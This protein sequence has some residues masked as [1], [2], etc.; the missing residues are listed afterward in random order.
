MYYYNA[1]INDMPH[2]TPYGDK[3]GYT[4]DLTEIFGPSSGDGWGI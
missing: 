2:Y 4:G 1:L 3:S